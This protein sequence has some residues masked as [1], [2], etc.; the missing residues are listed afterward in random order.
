[1]IGNGAAP[2]GALLGGIIGAAWGLEA[3]MLLA[4]IILPIA[5]GLAIPALRT[6]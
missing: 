1:V 6:S 5:A 2:L 4:A 3:P